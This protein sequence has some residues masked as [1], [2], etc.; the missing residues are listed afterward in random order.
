VKKPAAA[1]ILYERVS[2]IDAFNE[3]GFDYPSLEVAMPKR[4]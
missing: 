4:S 2:D 1:R 3:E